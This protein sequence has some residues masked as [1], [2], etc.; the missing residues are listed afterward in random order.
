MVDDLICPFCHREMNVSVERTS[1]G[2][3]ERRIT[4]ANP[5]C[6]TNSGQPPEEEDRNR[7]NSYT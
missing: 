5:E 1:S 4:C 7:N 2:N 3:I 6:P